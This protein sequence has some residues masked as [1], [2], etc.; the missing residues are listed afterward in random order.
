MSFSVL[1]L[2]NKNVVENTIFNTVTK[3]CLNVIISVLLT[4]NKCS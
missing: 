4:A 1:S 2:E 3:K